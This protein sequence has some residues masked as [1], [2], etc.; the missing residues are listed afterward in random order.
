MAH[1]PDGVVAEFRTV[2][3]GDLAQVGKAERRRQGVDLEARQPHVPFEDRPDALRHVLAHFQAHHRAEVP[4]PDDLDD[5]GQQVAR[6]VFLDLQVG[7]TRDPEGVGGRDLEAGEE[8]VEIGRD[9]F[10][11]PDELAP[12]RVETEFVASAA[13][14]PHQPRQ[15]LGNLDPG[16]A[17]ALASVLDHDR[18]VQ[19]EVRDVGEGMARVERQRRQHGE[20][21]ALEVRPQ[22]PLLLR[23]EVVV[24]DDRD[25]F[26][27]EL[28]QQVV[29]PAAVDEPAFALEMGT[30]ARQLLGRRHPVGRRLQ[31]AAFELPHQARDANHEELVQ[32]A[33]VDRQELDPLE[34]GM[35]GIA[36]LLE[37]PAVELEPAQLPVVVVLGKTGL[38]G[39]REP[40]G[41]WIRLRLHG[42]GRRRRGRR[43]HQVLSGCSLRV[44]H[45]NR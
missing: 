39:R 36:R 21:V 42:L 17:L 9:Q 44:H 6:L 25:P 2:E 35:P 27:L 19:A 38:D 10:L 7:V 20:D 43:L 18:Q 5:R 34:Q 1:G 3:E 12:P 11:D 15:H 8:Q 41:T 40:P 29:V 32:V 26:L 14:R 22:L 30:D 28:G 23:R 16:E 37:N 45:G 24:G 4:L 13:R 31:C 33:A